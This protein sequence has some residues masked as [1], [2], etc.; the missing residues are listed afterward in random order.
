[1]TEKDIELAIINNIM[2]DSYDESMSLDLHD[3]I[4]MAMKYNSKIFNEFIF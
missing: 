2:N 4:L 3:N 1:M